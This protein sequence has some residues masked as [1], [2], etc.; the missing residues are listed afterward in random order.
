M[1]KVIVLEGPDGGGKTTLAGEIIEAWRT[2][3]YPK[4]ESASITKSPAGRETEWKSNYETW[5]DSHSLKSRVTH[6]DI[7]D[8]TP[9]ISEFVYGNVMRGKSRLD[10]PIDVWA[11]FD[12]QVLLVFCM[13][14][15][16]QDSDRMVI[17]QDQFGNK[18]GQG[19]LYR[20]RWFY[21]VIYHL[22]LG[23]HYL[24]E[25]VWY[26]FN[27]APAFSQESA[28]KRIGEFVNG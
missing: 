9:E 6:L 16:N 18:V 23:S 26:D 2:G 10:D 28:M 22:F 20:I 5:V 14:E 11:G 19:H 17:H 8:R 25:P 1:G 7:L 13:G 3:K 15:P 4:I 24:P 27:G 21:K 12:E